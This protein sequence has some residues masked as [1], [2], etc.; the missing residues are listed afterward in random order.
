LWPEE[1][2]AL[3]LQN[4]RQALSRLRR[5]IGDR[6]R[7]ATE[8]QPYL[9]ASRESIQLNPA[10]RGQVD[11]AAFDEALAFTRGHAHRHLDTCPL[12]VE[13]LRR[14]V[15]LYRGEFLAGFSLSSAPFEEWMV[16]QRERLHLEALGALHALAAGHEQR[17][18]H[19]LVLRY[20]RRQLELEGW[21]EEAHRQCVRALALSGQRSAAL[22][23]YEACRRILAEELGVE[24]EE[25]TR[26]LYERIREGGNVDALSRVPPH[27]LP[28]QPTPLLGREDELAQVADRL[29]D[30]ACRLLTLTGPG[31]SGKTRLA[32]EAAAAQVYSF[33]DGVFWVPLSGLDAAA[34]IVPAI[35]QALGLSFYRGGDPR[36]Q[37][38]RQVRGW[39]ALLVLDNFEHLLEGA[40]LV[41]GILAAA[42]GIQ[43]LVTSREQLGLQGEH[44]FLVPGM[45]YPGRQDRTGGDLRPPGK[46]V[47][48]VLEYGSVQL[49]LQAVRRV[50]PGYQPACSD[51]EQVA[52]LCRLVEGMPLAI[53]LAASWADALFVAEIARQ[54]AQDLGFLEAEWRDLPPRQRNMRAVFD[55]SWRLLSDPEQRAFAALTVFRG[56]FTAEAAQ[57]VAGADVRT[58]R[59][60]VHKSFLEVDAG[61]RYGVHELLRQ[62]GAEHLAR[63]ADGGREARDRHATYYAEYLHQRENDVVRGYVQETMHELDNIR[64]G[65]DWAARHGKAEEILQSSVSLWLV[66]FSVRWVQEG[67]EAFGRA[68]EGL[69]REVAGEPTE[70]GEVALGLA[71]G[72]QSF[73]LRWV[74]EAG[75]AARLVQEGLSILRKHGARRELAM[76]LYYARFDFVGDDLQ[77]RRLIEECLAISQKTGFY[78]G[79]VLALRLLGRNEEA[80]EISREANDRRGM[81]FALVH[82]GDRAYDQQAYDEAKRLYEE[83]LTFARELGRWWLIG[84]L[85]AHL[86]DVALALGEQEAARVH[87]WEALARS[88]D[89]H[90]DFT[91]LE[92][93]ER[94]GRLALAL[95]D[96][97]TAAGHY[98]QALEIAVEPH[99]DMWLREDVFSP[100]LVAGM[101]ALLAP[102]DEKKAVELAALSRYHPSSREET[103]DRAQ[104]L[105][106]HLQAGLAP[107]AFA[108]AQAR[109]RARDLEATVRELLA[110]L[111]QAS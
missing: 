75:R 25:E 110:E 56:G 104:R 54:T 83:S 50:R 61:G 65:W 43:V 32:L 47:R 40:G 22:A 67:A 81:A 42:P 99:F 108:A 57:E 89:M 101:A 10:A 46:P 36:Q 1:P 48:S 41:A 109:G 44:L 105:L 3:A 97:E 98:R 21:R 12:C 14:A 8:A 103:R 80:L 92:A 66:Y 62:Y 77:R 34:S 91:I 84:E 20:A 38:L 5:A 102:A 87:Y 18:E 45:D 88:R 79:Q 82:L 17:G 29:Q 35:A 55:T 60:L 4:L 70:T 100:D 69:R 71:L 85:Y 59:A 26:V 39:E 9:L 27:N 33:R 73:F 111:E 90:D 106:D 15:E 93:H 37:L 78:L 63:A 53:L 23:Q 86:G 64:A 13:R 24:P 31:G 58:L 96:P 51:L 76:C 2:E 11:V 19:E 16:A 68:V 107:A 94:L 74:R 52:E 28:A 72:G 30:P 49:F 6:E 7:A 95:H